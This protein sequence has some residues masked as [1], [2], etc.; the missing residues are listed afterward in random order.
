M[1]MSSES[2][3]LRLQL[4][5]YICKQNTLDKSCLIDCQL[6]HFLLP[7]QVLRSKHLGKGLSSPSHDLVLVADCC[8][9][10]WLQHLLPPLTDSF[11]L[12]SWAACGLGVL[13]PELRLPPLCLD[14]CV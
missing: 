7:S 4:R 14:W 3:F 2:L 9:P 11:M 6:A 12:R 1:D 13:G 5:S 10:R 8:P